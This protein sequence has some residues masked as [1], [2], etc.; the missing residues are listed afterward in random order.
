[1]IRS[2]ISKQ[3]TCNITYVSVFRFFD[4][5]PFIQCCRIGE[6]SNNTTK[7]LYHLLFV[8]RFCCKPSMYSKNT[9]SSTVSRL[10]RITISLYSDNC[11]YIDIHRNGSLAT[12]LLQLPLVLQTPAL[13]FHSSGT[14]PW[15]GVASVHQG[16]TDMWLQ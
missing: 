16:R 9:C 13:S 4:F 12:Y 8:S 10:I 2:K 7:V 6:I 5:Q 1:M 11:S 14:L 15:T 3:L